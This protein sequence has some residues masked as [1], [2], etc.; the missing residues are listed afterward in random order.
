MRIWLVILQDKELAG[1]P[2]IGISFH[3]GE[4]LGATAIGREMEAVMRL[5]GRCRCVHRIREVRQGDHYRTTALLRTP[6]T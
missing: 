5:Q 4:E 1:E 6:I 2:D 3:L